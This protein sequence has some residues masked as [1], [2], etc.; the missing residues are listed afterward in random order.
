MYGFIYLL[1]KIKTHTHTRIIMKKNCIKY[2]DMIKSAVDSLKD[3]QNL[4]NKKKFQW[5][6]LELQFQF[7]N[8]KKC[9]KKWQKNQLPINFCV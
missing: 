7:K 3:S 9:K 2:Y 1:K 5:I 8:N 6:F 4:T